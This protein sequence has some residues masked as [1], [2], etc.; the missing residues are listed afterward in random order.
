MCNRDGIAICYRPRLPIPEKVPP[1]LAPLGA[2]F[3]IIRSPDQPDPAIFFPLFTF[4]VLGTFG[5]G[6]NDDLGQRPEQNFYI[7]EEC[8]TTVALQGAGF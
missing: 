3:K 1:T 5:S 4:L 6:P 2:Q 7:G 8:P